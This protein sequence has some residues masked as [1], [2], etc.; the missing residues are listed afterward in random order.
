MIE[1]RIKFNLELHIVFI[2][3]QKVLD[4]LH[5]KILW[6]IMMSIE[7]NKQLTALI[8]KIKKLENVKKS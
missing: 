1:K 4:S 3:F 5:R 2:D 8:I 6:G 7:T